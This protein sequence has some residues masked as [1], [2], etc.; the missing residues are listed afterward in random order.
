MLRNALLIAGNDLRRRV[1]NR[2]AIIMGIV[3]PIMMA[4]L[5][6]AAFGGGFAFKATIGVADADRSEL[7][8]GITAGLTGEADGDSP[9]TF[10]VVDPGTARDDV[11]AGKVDAALVFP[12]GYGASVTAG[13]PKPLAVVA[14]ADKRITG[15]VATS[16]ADGISARVRATFLSVATALG[17][18]TNPPDAARVQQVVA[19][20]QQVDIPV[21]VGLVDVRG[22]Y[23]PVAYFGASMAMLFLFFSVGTGARSLMT[24]RKEGTLVRV[25]SAPVGDSAILLGKAIGV[26]VLGLVSMLVVWAAT[27]VV[28]KAPWG[29]PVAV[30]AV[31]VAVVVAITGVSTLVT[32]FARTDAQAD[33][34][35]SMVAFAFALIGGSFMQPG[36]MPGALRTL[37]LLTPNGWALRALTDIGAGGAGLAAVWPA[38]LALFVIGLVTGAVGLVVLRRKVAS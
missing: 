30:F 38:V 15:E 24:E 32:G 28:F 34:I 18:P 5:I 3:T 16:V 1:R 20:A 37:A 26:L 36:A 9:L 35:T 2:T 25:R 11:L 33:G 19:E 31:I 14:A 13:D 12:E 10:V 27:A 7:S 21:A 22:S 23:S 29:D 17:D 6:G 8:Q 4:A